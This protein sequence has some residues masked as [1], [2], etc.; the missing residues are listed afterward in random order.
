MSAWRA[1]RQ[2]FYIG[3]ILA[4]VFTLLFI[5]LLNF[6]VQPPT[7]TD[8][9]QN[10]DETGVDVGGICPVVDTQ[11]ARSIVTL[12]ERPFLVVDDIY[13]AV[14]YFENQN[15]AAGIKNIK[16]RFRFYD[17]KN[18][19]VAERRGETFIGPNQRSAIFEP[20]IKTGN[21]VPTTVFFEFL[22]EPTWL[23]TPP[24]FSTIQ[25]V[26]ANQELT[27]TD[28][29]PR[30]TATIENRTFDHL[31]DIEVIA[32]LYDIDDNA[33]TASKTLIPV[34]EQNTSKDIFFTWPAPFPREAVRI[35]LIPRINVFASGNQ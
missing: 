13:N 5:A 28:S 19:I 35:E 9:K 24:K 26:V 2:L 25:L 32:I 12:W 15:L 31:T 21:R 18:I 4:I 20:S 8:G 6:L 14:A 7:C 1:K 27:N 17:D 11:E 10:G 34:M 22:E 23:V 29:S 33:V 3:T 16:Y 30:L